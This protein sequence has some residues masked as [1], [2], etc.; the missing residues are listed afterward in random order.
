MGARPGLA[1]WPPGAPAMACHRL[2]CDLGSLAPTFVGSRDSVRRH[3]R[4]VR[5]ARTSVPA[6]DDVHLRR[7][8]S[9]REGIASVDVCRRSGGERPAQVAGGARRRTDCA[10]DGNGAVDTPAGGRRRGGRLSVSSGGLVRQRLLGPGGLR[11]YRTPGAGVACAAPRSFRSGVAGDS[12]RGVHQAAGVGVRC[13]A[14]AGDARQARR[15]GCGGRRTVVR[16]GVAA[17]VVA[18]VAERTP[19]CAVLGFH[20]AGVARA[21]YR[22]QRLQLLVSALRRRRAHGQFAD[23]DGLFRHDHRNRR[24]P[25]PGRIRRAAG[26]C[27]SSGVPRRIWRSP[28]R[29]RCMRCS[30]FRPKCTSAS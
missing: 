4:V 19:G 3:C 1:A 20:P 22:R 18:M 7:R 26:G 25:A 10:P 21:A 17:A 23:T 8:R 13:G 9:S 28:R 15:Q 14:A 16:C 29:C 11:L 2:A 30:C 5:R 27:V 12:G 24:I 6:V